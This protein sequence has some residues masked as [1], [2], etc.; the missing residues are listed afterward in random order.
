MTELLFANKS[1][2]IFSVPDLLAEIDE[3]DYEA[4]MMTYYEWHV[5]MWS[6]YF[7]I[8]MMH[9]FFYDLIFFLPA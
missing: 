3:E 9:F 1:A 6:F 5:Y 4:Y 8:G 2:Y 7:N